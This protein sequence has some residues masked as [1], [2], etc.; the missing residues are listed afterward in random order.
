MIDLDQPVGVWM[1]IAWYGGYLP[2]LPDLCLGRWPADF[3]RTG[4]DRWK[5]WIVRSPGERA[6]LEAALARPVPKKGPALDFSAGPD[7]AVRA[8]GPD[9]DYVA[10]YQPV[11]PEWPWITLVSL[12]MTA[13]HAKQ[14]GAARGRYTWDAD[15]T[16]AAAID[17]MHRL[18]SIV[19]IS[20]FRAPRRE[21]LQ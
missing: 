9:D 12:T 5:L 21:M 7:A 15:E 13:A 4:L 16:E 3:R 17:R 18:R 19:P 10:L 6:A 14:L 8:P 11:T 2:G 20:D 1:P